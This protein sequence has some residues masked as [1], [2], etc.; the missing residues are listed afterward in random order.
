[1]QA[2][3]SLGECEMYADMAKEALDSVTSVIRESGAFVSACRRRASN[4]ASPSP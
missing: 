2:S 4:A 1:M 3:T